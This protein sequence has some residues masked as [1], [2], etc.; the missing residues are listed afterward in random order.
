MSIDAN[1]KIGIPATP[2]PSPNQDTMDGFGEIVEQ[3]EEEHT[4]DN[5]ANKEEGISRE[6]D[7]FEKIDLML[8]SGILQEA[9]YLNS[10]NDTNQVQGHDWKAT[11]DNFDQQLANERLKGNNRLPENFNEILF[12]QIAKQG[13]PL[14]KI[15]YEITETIWTC[16]CAR[17]S[18]KID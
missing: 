4:G 15:R 12:T 2:P 7:S 11:P 18:Y 8:V 5:A 13:F 17:P 1:C 10:L 6:N 9:S 16:D 3:K 14:K